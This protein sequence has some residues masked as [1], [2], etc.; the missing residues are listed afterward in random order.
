MKF[1]LVG[2]EKSSS[3]AAWPP[4][5]ALA[6][7]NWLSQL[8]AIGVSVRL[9]ARMATDGGTGSPLAGTVTRNRWGLAA[10]GWSPMTALAG[11]H[12]LA[13]SLAID[14]SWCLQP[15]VWLSSTKRG[16]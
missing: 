2:F 7:Q 4:T 12:Q 8:R 13:Q 5:T 16:L 9:E 3:A 15:I 6:G 14:A 11:A 10:I 1:N